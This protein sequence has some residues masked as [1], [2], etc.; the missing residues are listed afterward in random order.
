MDQWL[1]NSNVNSVRSN[2]SPFNSDR[3]QNL[4]KIEEF[5]VNCFKVRKKITC[6]KVLDIDKSIRTGF[7]FRQTL[8]YS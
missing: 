3:F 1:S 6:E 2:R 4:A 5:Q 8:I 7:R